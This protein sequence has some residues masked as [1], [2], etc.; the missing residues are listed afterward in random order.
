MLKQRVITGVLLGAFVVAAILYFPPVWF[1]LFVAACIAVGAREWAR[2][3][4]LQ[5]RVACTAYTAVCL[6]LMFALLHVSRE[7]QALVFHASFAWWLIAFVLVSIYPRGA[8]TWHRPL[9]LLPLGLVVLLPGWLAL[10]ALRGRDDHAFY[11]LLLIGLIV[12]ADSGAY[13]TG[14]ALGKH[15]LAVRVSPNK[16]WEGFAGGLLAACVLLWITQ[17]L[18]GVDDWYADWLLATVGVLVLA[19]ASVVGDLFES[20]L[21]RQAG[22]KDSGTILPGHGGVL[23]RIDSLTAA[24]PIYCVLLMQ[25]GLL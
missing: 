20:M 24:L 11:I 4:G 8:A 13:F 6:V 17:L 18:R 3:A 19:S 9:V 2:L 12:A 25:V 7:A 22:V 5:T 21:K 23:D 16:T 14:R 10:V 15:K 1:Q